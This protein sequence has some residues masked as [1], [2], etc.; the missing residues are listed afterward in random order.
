MIPDEH[1][2]PLFRFIVASDTLDT[3]NFILSPILSVMIGMIVNTSWNCLDES[4]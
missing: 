1:E 4:R 2:W 3:I